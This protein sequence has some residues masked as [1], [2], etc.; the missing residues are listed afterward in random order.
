MKP[1]EIYGF[2]GWVGSFAVFLI[3]IGWGYL[4]EKVLHS[5]GIY[6][7]PDKTWAL[8]IPSVFV[9]TMVFLILQYQFLNMAKSTPFSSYTSMQGINF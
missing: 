4:P 1:I 2:A 6:F 8:A 7:Y 3:F 5:L 9:I